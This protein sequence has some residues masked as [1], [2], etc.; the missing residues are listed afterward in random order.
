VVEFFFF[1]VNLANHG[2][3]STLQTA[4]KNSHINKTHPTKGRIRVFLNIFIFSSFSRGTVQVFGFALPACLKQAERS[5][6]WNK[7]TRIR[8]VF[9]GW[10][11][12]KKK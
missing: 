6:G 4:H 10:T 5:F 8:Q 7:N 2:S 11:E 9:W 1:S 12:R 3:T